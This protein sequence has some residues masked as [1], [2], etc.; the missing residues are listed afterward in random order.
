MAPTLTVLHAYYVR[1]GRCAT[2]LRRESNKP[3]RRQAQQSTVQADEFE[4]RAVY[5]KK[6]GATV[7]GYATQFCGAQSCEQT[8]SLDERGGTAAGNGLKERRKTKAIPPLLHMSASSP[9]TAYLHTALSPT[10]PAKMFQPQSGTERAARLAAAEAA[11]RLRARQRRRAQQNVAATKAAAE[12]AATAL[13]AAEAAAVAAFDSDESESDN[14]DERFVSHELRSELSAFDSMRTWQGDDDD[15]QNVSKNVSM[16]RQRRVSMVDNNNAGGGGDNIDRK[17]SNVDNGIDDAMSEM[18]T[19]DV[20]SQF[21]AFNVPAI[22]AARRALTDVVRVADAAVAADGGNVGGKTQ[23]AVAATA[24][25]A[26]Q[27]RTRLDAIVQLQATLMHIEE[28]LVT[29]LAVWRLQQQKRARES[30]ERAWRGG[31]LDALYASEAA[32]AAVTDEYESERRLLTQRLAT[33]CERT[34]DDARR[35][36]AAV[37]IDVSGR[38]HVLLTAD[39]DADVSFDDATVASRVNELRNTALRSVDDFTAGMDGDSNSND[40]SDG[41]KFELIAAVDALHERVLSAQMSLENEADGA[42]SNDEKGGDV[43][44]ND[45]K[46]DDVK[47]AANTSD[48]GVDDDNGSSL[49]T[50][51]HR[52]IVSLEMQLA[53]EQA[54]LTD[55]K[56]REHA[57]AEALRRIQFAREQ[58][59]NVENVTRRNRTNVAADGNDTTDDGDDATGDGDD[60]DDDDGDGSSGRGS[61][62]MHT[63][64]SRDRESTSTSFAPS[65]ATSGAT[66]ER[67]SRRMSATNVAAA[68]AMEEQMPASRP[69]IPPAG[70]AP[71]ASHA[72]M[73][74]N[75]SRIHMAAQ[76][77]QIGRETEMVVEEHRLRKLATFLARKMSVRDARVQAQRRMQR[78]SASLHDERRT[79]RT[80]SR[81]CKT[82]HTRQST[83][84]MQL[85]E[86]FHVKPD[87]AQTV[88]ASD[89]QDQTNLISNDEIP[90]Y[91]SA[92]DEY[93][94]GDDPLH[95]RDSLF[96][97]TL[98][99]RD[100]LVGEGI[101]D[102]TDIQQ[103]DDDSDNDETAAAAAAAKAAS[104]NI[105]CDADAAALRELESIADSDIT[106]EQ[107]KQ[108]IMLKRQRNILQEEASAK[109]AVAA[110]ERKRRHQQRSAEANAER[111]LRADETRREHEELQ[112]LMAAQNGATT[113][114]LIRHRVSRESAPSSTASEHALSLSSSGRS[115]PQTSQARVAKMR[116]CPD[117]VAAGVW[118]CLHF[119]LIATVPR[120]RHAASHGG[121]GSDNAA[122]AT[123]L[124][125]VE[126]YCSQSELGANVRPWRR[127]ATTEALSVTMQHDARRL[128]PVLTT[129]FRPIFVGAAALCRGQ[130]RRRILLRTL[131]HDAASGRVTSLG[132]VRVTLRQAFDDVSTGVKTRRLWPL[133]TSSSDVTSETKRWKKSKTVRHRSERGDNKTGNVS[134]QFEGGAETST[135]SG[136]HAGVNLLAGECALRF[137]GLEIARP[138]SVAHTLQLTSVAPSGQ[139]EA[140]T[141]MRLC[142]EVDTIDMA[143][144][145]AAAA[146][147]PAI[148]GDAH[149]DSRLCV[150]LSREVVTSKVTPQPDGRHRLAALIES[151]EW[152]PFYVT[153]AMPID[154]S[155][156]L[157]RWREFSVVARHACAPELGVDTSVRVR[158]FHCTSRAA[159]SD[160]DDGDAAQAYSENDENHSNWSHSATASSSS[161]SSSSPTHTRTE[162]GH[163]VVT[164][165]TLLTAMRDKAEFAADFDRVADAGSTLAQALV[166][167]YNESG[168]VVNEEDSLHSSKPFDFH[169]DAPPDDKI[170]GGGD[171]GGKDDD[172]DDDDDDDGPIGGTS[173]EERLHREAMQR[174]HRAV[175]AA[176]VA[177]RRRVRNAGVVEA[178]TPGRFCIT[179]LHVSRLATM[180]RSKR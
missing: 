57:V 97:F 154:G 70:A 15:R 121:E 81:I 87:S 43:N 77:K 49:L 123:P 66:S 124:L 33:L 95:R 28:R 134:A 11:A 14:E 92:F 180:A 107:R 27:L 119:T 63:S 58:K 84:S 36:T 159:G 127:I 162:L 111:V 24:T 122:V 112:A 99:S 75:V 105:L 13:V 101:L 146:A 56:H 113:R 69:S 32:T 61:A 178:R 90:E 23:Q 149:F 98:P 135:G 74:T 156:Q 1:A 5:A 93:A 55:A 136:G 133:F 96:D 37:D 42:G 142:I 71:S 16:K 106:W 174:R 85:N 12:A 118:L 163:C 125:S 157:A 82:V 17:L 25:A 62:S 103:L 72:S 150:E 53:R 2:T 172:E 179:V 26:E 175:M 80:L 30:S 19:K 102:E 131:A 46:S 7:V 59:K 144:G 3:R 138:Q 44:D 54:V 64:V 110:S 161:S 41:G 115:M 141:V 18:D 76:L 109:A 164:W 128:H 171:D 47:V 60:D 176:A 173:L 153:V 166:D 147:V 83:M 79:N 148:G 50:A 31:Q 139:L 45:V 10:T 94:D 155:R 51:S 168:D 6:D 126:V 88:S 151:T 104:K 20:N 40:E 160:A 8:A 73:N 177:H 165:R 9:L 140:N 21:S 143:F 91:G 158:F 48:G 39:A 116:T 65:L 86:T 89:E 114:P 132:Q 68:T 38:L 34:A 78:T 129:R 29:A 100:V 52:R 22:A 67:T 4:L 137:D 170:D 145:A 120:W 167:E 35:V 108:L 130:A 152:R 169:G 117:H